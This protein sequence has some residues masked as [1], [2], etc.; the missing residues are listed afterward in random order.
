MT[1]QLT[2]Q[3]AANVA[4]ATETA[5]AAPSVDRY[6]ASRDAFLRSSGSLAGG[7]SSNFR[8]GGD[9]VPLFFERG[10]GAH[11]TDVDGNDYV[12]YV[13]GMGPAILGHAPA[14][15]V[16]AVQ[17][18]ADLGQLFAGQTMAEV[19]LAERVVSIVPCA[20]RV[21]FG[22]SGTEMVQ[23]AL[24]LAR[25]ATER[26]VIV[27][28]EGHYHGWLDPALASIAPPLDD[29]EPDDVLVPHLPSLGQL[30]SSAEH[31]AVLRWNDRA[32]LARLFAGPRKDRIAAV[33][34]EPILCNT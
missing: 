11:L 16:A 30:A 20:E 22:S 31:V 24:R 14:T 9:P 13:L 29:D 15:V 23:A 2:S 33:I 32:G 25:A 19:E 34:C 4:A 10:A 18:Q 26:D 12:D 17:A 5:T 7:V 6:A 3:G 27:K 28:F 8:A 1:R 21:R